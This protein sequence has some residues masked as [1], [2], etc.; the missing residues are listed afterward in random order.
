[1]N[2]WRILII[3][4]AGAAFIVQ[5]AEAV[6]ALPGAGVVDGIALAAL[7]EHALADDAG[8]NGLIA[9]HGESRDDE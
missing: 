7:G 5:V 2:D 4:Y 6:E 8:T 3:T 1:M 9:G